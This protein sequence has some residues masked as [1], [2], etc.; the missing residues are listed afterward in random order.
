MKYEYDDEADWL[1]IWFVNL[2]QEKDNYQ[3]EI[4]PE[5]LKDKVGL[6]FDKNEKLMG[7]EFLAA[8]TFFD[9]K[10]LKKIAESSYT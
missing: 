5:E 8:S 2:E 3:R 7:I 6:I 4:W 9:E 1:F 10:F